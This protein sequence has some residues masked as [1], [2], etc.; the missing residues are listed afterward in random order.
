MQVA[1]LKAPIL[2]IRK[3]T[4][5]QSVGYGRDEYIDAGR[6]LA[7][8]AMGYADGLHRISSGKAL[9]GFVAGKKVPMVGRVSMD[10]TCYD[11]TY[12]DSQK[13]EQENHISIIDEHQTVDNLAEICN[14]IG[15]EIFT[16]LSERVKR[17]YE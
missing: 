1:T 6:K 2:Q 12:I 4:E 9:Y 16:S 8:V 7:V 11:V 14:T 10:M 15:Y 13:L 17:V 3:T 5:K